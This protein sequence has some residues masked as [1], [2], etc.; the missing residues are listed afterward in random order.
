MTAQALLWLVLTVPLAAAGLCLRASSPT[1][2]MAMVAAGGVTWAALALAAAGAVMGFGPLTIAGDWLHF[3]ALSGYHTTV[4]ALVFGASSVFARRYFSLEISE[5]GL[6]LASARKFGALWFG[7][8]AAMVWVLA[9]NNLGLMWVGIEATTLL[10]AF[11]IS[12]HTTPLSLE[13]M[14]K[15]LVVC[16]VGVAFAFVGTLLTASA[17]SGLGHGGH[18]LLW[19]VLDASAGRLAPMSMKL[20]FIFVVVGYGTKAGLAPL[21]SWLPDAHSQAPAPVSALLSGFML[22]AALYCIMR[23]LPLVAGATGSPVWGREIVVVFGIASMLVAAAFIVFQHDAK[24]LLAYSSVEHLGIIA[25]GLGLGG[26][27]T[28]AGLWHTLNHS[29][30]KTLAFFSV[31][32]LGKMYGT[33]DLG[34]MGGAL[35]RSPVWGS[36]FFFGLLALIGVAP[37]AIFMSEL[38][39]LRAAV[40]AHAFATLV[41]FLVAAAIVFAGALRHAIAPAWGEETSAPELHATA[42]GDRLLVFGALGLLLVL[43]LWLPAPLRQAMEAAAAVV[44]GRP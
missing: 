20:A 8:A 32:W 6:T 26:V 44:G 12:V 10:T 7:S 33:H 39:I 23:Y 17:A 34:R 42:L 1:R 31:G 14:W 2:I 28:F 19:T 5:G 43:G 21:H 35:R 13:A 40:E 29:V 24:R 36:G 15:Y 38:Q 27:G 9:C 22:T 30:C 3:D 25:I 4:L 16:S 18:V 37:F 41:L 11:L